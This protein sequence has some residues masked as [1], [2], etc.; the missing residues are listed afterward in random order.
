MSEKVKR[1]SAQIYII[2]AGE[3]ISRQDLTTLGQTG[4]FLSNEPQRL[5]EGFDGDQPEAGHASPTGRYVLSYCST[6][7]KGSHKLE[8]EMVTPNGHA[9][10]LAQVQRRRLPA[11]RCSPKT[12]RC[13]K[14]SRR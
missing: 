5:Q 8:I 1:T 6:K 13:S 4:V 11:Q 12:S 14:R 10:G 9:Q 2:G 3:K 7:K